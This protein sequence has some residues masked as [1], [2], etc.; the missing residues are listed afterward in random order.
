MML[1]LIALLALG[2]SL[3]LIPGLSLSE[4]SSFLLLEPNV[5]VAL[6][7][8]AAQTQS[9]DT[10]TEAFNERKTALLKDA[11]PS[12]AV[13]LGNDRRFAA[14]AT[15]ELTVE[16]RRRLFLRAV[17]LRGVASLADADVA[18]EVGLSGAALT[19]VQAAANG[20]DARDGK[21]ADAYSAILEKI[22]PQDAK[23][24]AAASRANATREKARALA[25][26]KEETALL[27]SVP[28]PVRAAWMKMID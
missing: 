7:L 17:R 22:P 16:Q 11:K 12:D 28:A 19:K 24:F 10:A 2:Q 6:G 23:A 26:K 18:R 8:S 25:R 20:M 21:V 27:A 1:K 15:Q 4:Q 9:I 14:E 5:Q 3:P 13:L